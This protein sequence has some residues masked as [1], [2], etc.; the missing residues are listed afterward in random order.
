MSIV[1]KGLGFEHVIGSVEELRGIH[2]E[3]IEIARQKIIDRL[4]GHCRAFIARSP[5]CLVATY[6]REG[7]CDVSPRGGPAGFVEVLDEKHLVFADAKGNRLAD[8]LS[9]V[10][11]TGRAGLLF[12]IPGLD[13]TLRVNGRACVTRDPEILARHEIQEGRPPRLA[14]GIEVDEAFLHCAKAFIR[15]ELWEPE[16]WK[17]PD[18]LARPAQIWKDHA[19]IKDSLQEIQ[20]FLEEDYATNLYWKPGD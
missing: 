11:E 3:P 17:G 10:V 15:S 6:D 9:N 12:L 14:I 8:T 1:E 13:E 19:A 7:R 18:G 2:G 5:F 4:D 16:S 20:E